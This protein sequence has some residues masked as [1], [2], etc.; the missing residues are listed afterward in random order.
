MQ[1]S[2]ESTQTVGYFNLSKVGIVFKPQQKEHPS[3]SRFSICNPLKFNTELSLN[4]DSIN[5]KVLGKHRCLG[6]NNKNAM[7]N[8]TQKKTNTIYCSL[9]FFDIS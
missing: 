1:P 3:Y 2:Y 5:H 9:V 8:S 7:H 6:K 4:L